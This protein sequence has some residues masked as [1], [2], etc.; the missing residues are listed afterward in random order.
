LTDKLTKETLKILHFGKNRT[1]TH[2]AL[3]FPWS[4]GFPGWHLECTAMS[5]NTWEIIL[6][7]TVVEWIY[8]HHECEIH[9]T[10]SCT[11]QT[12]VNYWMRQHDD[13]ER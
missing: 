9:K 3:A 5:T 8:P 2:N 4:E 6:I 7:F 10:R 12:P 1:T 11:G 13:F